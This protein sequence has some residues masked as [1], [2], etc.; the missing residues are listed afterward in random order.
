[1]FYRFPAASSKAIEINSLR[2]LATGELTG[3][4]AGTMF[5]AV[6]LSVNDKGMGA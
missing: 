4:A 1:M 5:R 3:V 6:C 2:F